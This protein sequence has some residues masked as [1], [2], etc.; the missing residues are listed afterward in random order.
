MADVL[1]YEALP[2]LLRAVDNK[3]KAYRNAALNFAETIPGVAATRQWIAKAQKA[4]PEL[5]AEIIGMLG[6]RGDARALPF[7]ESSLQAR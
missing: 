1:G 2:S 4:N 5:R 7:L 6:R 3:D